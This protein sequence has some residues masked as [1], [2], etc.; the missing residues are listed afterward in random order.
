MNF[1]AQK[2]KKILMQENLPSSRREN[3]FDDFYYKEIALLSGVGGYYIDF[4]KK[5]SQIDPQGREILN[6]PSGF[7]PSLSNILKFYAED[8]KERI[9]AIYTNCSKG[10]SFTTT[11]KMVTYDGVS[12]LAKAT[13]KPI[14]SENGT[15]VGLRGIF[16]DISS[17][18]NK[19]IQL[20]NSLQ[21]IT[22][23]NDRVL[24]YA[25]SLSRNL[26]SNAHN[27]KMSLELLGE[28]ENK[29][30]ETELMDGLS[31][32]SED[33]CATLQN[34]DQIISIH[35]RP[36]KGTEQV[37]FIDCLAAARISMSKLISDTRTEIFTDFS[38]APE[39]LF[40]S[41]Y[42]ISIFK[43]LISNAIRYKHPERNPVIDIY[44]LET[45]GNISL[46]VKDN[47]SGFDT[48]NDS[49]KFFNSNQSHLNGEI[50]NEISMF[51]LKSQVESL[52]GSIAVESTPNNGTTFKIQ[53]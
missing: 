30:D 36:N 31:M 24:K 35:Q 22:A 1:L 20:K 38:E 8:E 12:F 18:K 25:H 42:L 2:R 49:R 39:V 29:K 13:G 44:S 16:Q 37:S 17:E 33:L 19:E 21:T 28:I 48:F 50:T 15:I 34:L 26:N 9:K 45:D 47:G 14:V 4:I 6:V 46:I 40:I 53:F 41:D 3:P 52:Q 5:I 43:N 51:M 23:L 32:I 7:E 11:V 10:E 27:L